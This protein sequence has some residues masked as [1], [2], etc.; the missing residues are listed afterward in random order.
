M[1]PKSKLDIETRSSEMF[2]NVILL[3]EQMT[4]RQASIFSAALNLLK[5]DI[6]QLSVILAFSS[7]SLNLS[8]RPSHTFSLRDNR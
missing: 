1:R 5:G 3:L 4:V 6:F 2:K 8:F 7:S